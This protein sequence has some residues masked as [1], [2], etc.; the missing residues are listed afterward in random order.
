MIGYLNKTNARVDEVIEY[1][2]VQKEMYDSLFAQ[3]ESA[4]VLHNEVRRIFK[5]EA[6]K[7]FADR[8]KWKTDVKQ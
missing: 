7:F 1:H 2:K 6:E 8:L 3:N 5:D 4:I